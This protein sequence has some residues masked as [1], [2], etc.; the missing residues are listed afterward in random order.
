MRDDAA[1]VVVTWN[2]AGH[3]ARCLESVAGYETV[4]VDNGSTDGTAALVR[5]R[6]PAVRLIEQGNRGMG[7]GNN[8]GMRA[9]AGGR[10]WLLL[11]S[12]AY[13]ASPGTL[14]RLVAFADDHRLEPAHRL[15]ALL[16]PRQRV[17]RHDDDG[18]V[19]IRCHQV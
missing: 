15:E 5:E 11:N 16:E 3:I 4:L 10:Y 17:V 18:D 6:F 1:V 13:L 9:A 8:T 12:D 7:G 14:E 19:R 2:A